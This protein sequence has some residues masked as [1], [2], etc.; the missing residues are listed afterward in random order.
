MST[1]A[2]QDSTV[3]LTPEIE[4]EDELKQVLEQNHY[5]LFEQELF[6]WVQ[7]EAQ[8]P[9]TRDLPTFLE[10]SDVEFHSMVLD[11]ADGELA[12]LDDV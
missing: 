2:L 9:A 1:E 12:V 11:I 6:G 4:Q 10:W 7:D 5:L 8:W 3:Y